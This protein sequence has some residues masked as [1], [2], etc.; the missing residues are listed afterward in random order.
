MREHR[1][2]NTGVASL[3]HVKLANDKNV[4]TPLSPP[5]EPVACFDDLTFSQ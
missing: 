1:R 3:P 2:S 4:W 5:Q